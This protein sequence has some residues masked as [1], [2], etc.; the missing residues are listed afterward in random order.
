M[1]AGTSGQRMRRSMLITSQSID[2]HSSS[3]S[4]FSWAIGAVGRTGKSMDTVLIGRSQSV[5][6]ASHP[7]LV[8]DEHARFLFHLRPQ[9]SHQI[10]EWRGPK[11]VGIDHGH[12][13][14]RTGPKIV[15]NLTS[16]AEGHVSYYIPKA[17]LSGV[18]EDIILV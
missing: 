7:D 12:Q 18:E 5:W 6:L 4:F 2:V 1:H 14:S 17:Y 9:L 13:L 8:S 15:H 16:R 10:R 11:V 3:W